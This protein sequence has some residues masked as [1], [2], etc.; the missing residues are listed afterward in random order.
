MNTGI[1]E[2]VSYSIVAILTVAYCILMIIANWRIFTKA[3]EAGWKAII[4]AYNTYV[5]YKLTWKTSMFWAM[6]I[7][8]FIAGI[9]NGIGGILCAVIYG[10]F[11]LVVVVISITQL[12]MLSKAFGHGVGFTIGLFI[13][14]PIFILILA[15]GKSQYIGNQS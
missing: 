3:G 15:F 2:G 14:S 12:H 4:P 9:A 1:V 8:A 11:M 13:L 7:L 6:L 5:L 10:I